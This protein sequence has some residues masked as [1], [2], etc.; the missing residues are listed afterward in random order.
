MLSIGVTKSLQGEKK[1]RKLK[2]VNISSNKKKIYKTTNNRFVTRSH[3]SRS[4]FFMFR[5]L[6]K[7]Q[8]ERPGNREYEVKSWLMR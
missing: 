5:L 8:E 6:G 1:E 2:G 7:S 4:L 3:H